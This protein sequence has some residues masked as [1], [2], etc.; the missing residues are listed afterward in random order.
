MT[1]GEFGTNLLFILDVFLL[2]WGSL[3]LSRIVADTAILFYDHRLILEKMICSFKIVTQLNYWF[4]GAFYWEKFLE[5][6]L[7]PSPLF[8]SDRANPICT[9]PYLMQCALMEKLCLV[10]VHFLKNE[11]GKKSKWKLKPPDIRA[12]NWLV[13]KKCLCWL[14]AWG[15]ECQS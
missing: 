1:W 13:K 9:L 3:L 15:A 10:C 14:I 2:I 7:Q 12:L 8:S 4:D 11:M 6:S 5:E